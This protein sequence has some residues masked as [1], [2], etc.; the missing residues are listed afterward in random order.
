MWHSFLYHDS[1][2]VWY[3]VPAHLI[4]YSRSGLGAPK[5]RVWHFPPISP[6]RRDGRPATRSTQ[7]PCT[8]M[9]WSPVAAPPPLEPH[10]RAHLLAQSWL[11]LAAAAI[12]P[13]RPSPPHPTSP[14]A[15]I[16]WER[17]VGKK[18]THF[19]KMPSRKQVINT[20]FYESCHFYWLTP[21][22][23]KLMTCRPL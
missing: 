7:G 19:A 13:V 23:Y 9:A 11:A 15:I 3:L 22:V 10:Q 20:I 14:M 21:K 12:Q 4:K 16:A 18:K 5:T 17:D 8:P 1:S 6:P 2:Y